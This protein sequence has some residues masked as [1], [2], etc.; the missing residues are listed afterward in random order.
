VTFRVA[1]ALGISSLAVASVQAQEWRGPGRIKGVV[2]DTSNKPIEGALV[3]LTWPQAAGSSSSR[4]PKPATTNAKGRWSFV[5]LVDGEWDIAIEAEGQIK[6]EDRTTVFS[7][8]AETLRLTMQPIP[9]EVIEA[10]K[11]EAANEILKRGNDAAGRG[12]YAEARAA[13]QEALDASPEERHADIIAGIA[14]TYLQ[15]DELGQATTELERA[16]AI[17]PDNAQSL[18]MMIAILASSGRDTEA[19]ALVARLPDE[20]ELDPATQ[21]NLGIIKYNEG[22]FDEA[23]EIFE[24]VIASSPDFASAYYFAGLVHLNS[25]RSAPALERL[26]KYLDLAPDGEHADEAGEFVQ[27]LESAQSGTP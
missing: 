19:E 27:Y 1:L 26:Q 17:D 20:S 5:G 13:Y 6:F 15:E 8:G 7:Q 23:G 11:R 25:E 16:L 10:Q 22:E 14:S 9:P 3:T 4:G 2:L 24:E 18:R 12:E 21:V